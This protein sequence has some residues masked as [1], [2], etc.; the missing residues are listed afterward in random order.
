MLTPNIF[1]VRSNNYPKGEIIDI[2]LKED[3]WVKE[4]DMIPTLDDRINKSQMTSASILKEFGQ[5]FAL[6]H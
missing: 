6:N 4:H 2:F 5:T 1:K 3:D